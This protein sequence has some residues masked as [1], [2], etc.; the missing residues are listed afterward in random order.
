MADSITEI[1]GLPILALDAVLSGEASAPPGSFLMDIS[2]ISMSNVGAGSL[3]YEGFRIQLVV[4]LSDNNPSLGTTYA[5]S[6]QDVSE[7]PPASDD[8]TVK[9]QGFPVRLGLTGNSVVIGGKS[10]PTYAWEIILDDEL[11]GAEPIGVVE[12]QGFRFGLVDYVGDGT[13]V[14]L[15]TDNDSAL[16]DQLQEFQ[17]LKFDLTPVA[18][19]NPIPKIGGITPVLWSWV[20]F[21]FNY[22][23]LKEK[24]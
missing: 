20:M 17:G 22:G 18:I 23:S 9:I 12:S 11:S 8:V 13:Y 19:T 2:L 10:Y 16:T 1:Q 7:T 15:L 14:L 4:D 5:V 6:V 21:N 24:M 3:E